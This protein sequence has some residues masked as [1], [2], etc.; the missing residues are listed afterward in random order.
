MLQAIRAWVEGAPLL[1]VGIVASAA[2]SLGTGLGALPVLG[3]QRITART[4][5]LLMSIAAGIMLAA[6]AF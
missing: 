5:D 4:Q 3:I 1:V 6:T 2:A